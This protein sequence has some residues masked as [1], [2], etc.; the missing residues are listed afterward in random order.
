VDRVGQRTNTSV[1]VDFIWFSPKPYSIKPELL[2]ELYQE[3]GF[4]SN[5]IAIQLDVSK[6]VVLER[7]RALGIHT[8]S[9]RVT[10]PNNYRHHEPPYGYRI[11]DGKLVSDKKEMQISRLVVELRTRQ[12]WAFARI[13]SEL[14]RK[15]YRNRRGETVW[16]HHSVNKI[17]QRWSGKL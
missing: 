7:L 15:G 6:T 4:S 2:R 13:A 16:H 17:F 14:M 12:G 10:N 5:Q 11:K 8:K 9:G 3:K 1:L